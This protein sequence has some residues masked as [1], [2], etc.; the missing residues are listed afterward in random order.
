MDKHL[1]FIKGL[2]TDRVTELREEFQHL[3]STI[4]DRIHY[5]EARRSGFSVIASALIAAAVAIF[6][7]IATQVDDQ[8]LQVSGY[9]F[10]AGVFVLGVVLLLI[11]SRQTNY[12]YPFTAATT[13]WKW[14]YRDAIPGQADFNV[15]WVDYVG[16]TSHRKQQGK[17]AY[18]NKWAAFF[19][20]EKELLTSPAV[21]LLQD[22]QQI[23]VLHVN[24]KYKN[25]FLRHLRTCLTIGFLAVILLT[26]STFG[27]FGFYETWVRPTVR[28]SIITAHEHK[29]TSSWRETGASRIASFGRE[30]RQLVLNMK[31]SNQGRCTTCRL[32]TIVMDKLGLRLPVG[33]QDGDPLRI[34]VPPGATIDA[35]GLIWIEK[36]L[37]AD[38]HIVTVEP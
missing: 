16:Q 31:I 25:D 22:I 13:T 6:P 9:V 20:K 14:F 32:S 34:A 18:T 2:P 11:F 1:E 38:M 24:E 17:N 19:E 4:A 29:V 5:A 36:R 15:R 27:T 3:I 7:F 10:C 26:A 28:T 8:R 30:E 35:S 21:S 33:Y 23:Y 12:S 37:A